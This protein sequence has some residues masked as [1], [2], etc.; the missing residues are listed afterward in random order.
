MR[1]ASE[2]LARP[3]TG[4]NWHTDR[5]T[6]PPEPAPDRRWPGSVYGVGDEPDAR[7]TLANERT[8][9]AWL[10]TALALVAGGVALILL[11]GTAGGHVLGAG[12]V[13][14]LAAVICVAGAVVAIGS[15]LR[16][17]R[18]ERAMRTASPLPAPGL[19]VFVVGVVVVV[20]LVLAALIVVAQ[21]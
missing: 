19:L 20:A 5:V 17:S 3:I 10:R 4:V 7:F 6:T 21:R 18:V 9:L 8:A 13:H 15:V 1:L 14:W 12:L 11:D 2:S 16:W